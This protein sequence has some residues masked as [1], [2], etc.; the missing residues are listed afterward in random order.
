[1]CMTTMQ[2]ETS[3]KRVRAYLAGTPVVDTIR[4]RLVWENPHYPAYYLPREDVRAGVLVP[5][6]ETRDS[7]ERGLARYFD[8]R[9]GERVAAKAAWQYPDSPV[10]E[11]RN[12]VRFEW[13]AL[14]AWF[15]EEEEV[16]V[17]PHDPH[18]RID[19]LHG[20]RHV[21]VSLRGV[22][23]AE[24]RRPV[25]LFETGLPARYYF[26]KTDVRMELLTPIA[27]RTG[28]AYKGFASYWVYAENGKVIEEDVAWSYA[29]PLPECA[30]IAGMLGFYD[31]TLD[32]DVDGVRLPKPIT[33]FS[34]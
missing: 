8:V 34:R 7:P 22:V 11:L 21:V 1:M 33:E 5:T 10:P 9:V 17:H 32:I 2:I 16:F 6:D 29:M 27:K 24:T 4:A 28:C 20:S 25:L 18:K 12:L 3:S 15:E 14:D 30:K 23:L 31:E 19:V 13:K 26:S